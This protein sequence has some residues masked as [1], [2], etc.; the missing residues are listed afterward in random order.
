MHLNMLD[1]ERSW[2]QRYDFYNLTNIRMN[3]KNMEILQQKIFNL[4]MDI[5]AWK[6]LDIDNRLFELGMEAYKLNSYMEIPKA[7]NTP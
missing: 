3:K 6:N 1:E 2:L 4:R 7:F 5:S